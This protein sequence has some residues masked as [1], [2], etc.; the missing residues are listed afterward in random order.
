[1]PFSLSIIIPVLNEAGL[2]QPHLARLQE[3]RRL[4]HQLIVVDGGSTDN[5]VELA[6]PLADLVLSAASGR[7]QQMNCGAAQANGELLLFLH[8]DT[9][10]P[11]DFLVCLNRVW[12]GAD[13]TWGWFPV[14]LSNRGLAYRIIGGFM[15]WR[16][17]LSKVST[18]DQALYVGRDLF[19]AVQGFPVLP[20]MED[21][22]ISKR[23]RRQ[24]A[25][26]IA[27]SR[28][29]AS[30]RRWEQRGLL[31]TVLLMWWLRWLYFIGVSPASLVRRYYPE[32][33]GGQVELAR[34]AGLVKV[35][36]E[37]TQTATSGD[38]Q[39][40]VSVAE[41]RGAL[42][43]ENAAIVIFAR[44]PEPGK[45]KTRLLEQ[46]SATDACR[47][48][49]AMLTRTVALVKNSS[50][51][52]LDLWVSSRPDAEFFLNLCDRDRIF[53]QQGDNLGTRMVD[54]VNHTL[55]RDETDCVL[56][57]GTDC[58][59]LT[60]AYLDA[61]LRALTEGADVVIGPS[62]DGGYVL[63]GLREP[64]PELFDN[65]PWSTPEVLPLTC[66]R[67]AAKG[68][69]LATLP[70]LWDVDRPEDLARLRAWAGIQSG[71]QPL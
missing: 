1:M 71:G 12:S 34:M 32:R 57:I 29:V 26:V 55:A 7:A 47:L 46:V 41:Q 65:M 33:H 18:G 23:L 30:S 44:Y 5:T 39:P 2:I 58:P 49:E 52:Q 4:G 66:E 14:R 8:V 61:A 53:V 36:S 28:A 64:Q 69:K 48:Y 19:A 50:L 37:S 6:R 59:V 62:E 20:L 9:V 60:S 67:V 22:A 35:V 25:P 42:R 54:A 17:R 68:L 40:E 43:Y 38:A 56:V 51:A 70:V 45:V 27:G 10:L 31:R 24:R 16:A 11:A 15:N 21:V 3:V 13:S 63:I